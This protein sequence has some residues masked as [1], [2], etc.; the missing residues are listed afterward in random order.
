M[1]T[2]IRVKALVG[3]A[4]FVEE[5]EGAITVE[6]FVIPLDDEEHRAGD[7]WRVGVMALTESATHG[8]GPAEAAKAKNGRFDA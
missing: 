6:E 5:L 7:L 2:R 8:A 4:N 1:E 3:G